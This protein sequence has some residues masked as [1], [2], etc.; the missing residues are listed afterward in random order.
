MSDLFR[1]QVPEARSNA[2]PGEFNR[3]KARQSREL[4]YIQNWYAQESS[5]YPDPDEFTSQIECVSERARPVDPAL[6]RLLMAESRDSQPVSGH[7]GNIY[8]A[9]KRSSR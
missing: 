9:D 7:C 1:K 4:A 3:R 8:L 6:R 5:G 2:R